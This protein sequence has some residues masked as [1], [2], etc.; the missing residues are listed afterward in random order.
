M[1]IFNALKMLNLARRAARPPFL[2]L[3]FNALKNGEGARPPPLAWPRINAPLR[4][5]L[6]AARTPGNRGFAFQGRRKGRALGQLLNSPGFSRTVS[7]LR[8]CP[9]PPAK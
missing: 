3:V 7:G 9:M 1:S 6:T 5:R 4:A 8:R 2:E